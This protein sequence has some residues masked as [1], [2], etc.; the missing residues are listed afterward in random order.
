MGKRS[1]RMSE[2]YDEDEFLLFMEEEGDGGSRVED[3]EMDELHLFRREEGDRHG[4]ARAKP[5]RDKDPGT[6]WL[7]DSGSDFPA[8]RASRNT[9]SSKT[10]AQIN[11]EIR[12]RNRKAQERIAKARERLS[13]AHEQYRKACERS[14]KAQERYKASLQK[15][16]VSQRPVYERIKE[17]QRSGDPLSD[18]EQSIM[19]G[20]EKM[21]R[22]LEELT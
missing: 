14:A 4:T 5:S 18:T 11:A 22:S 17:K 13:K 9:A 19:T 10:P 2:D 6:D 21:L 7:F 15:T 8:Y 20:Y 12:E 16:I 3:Y 1:R